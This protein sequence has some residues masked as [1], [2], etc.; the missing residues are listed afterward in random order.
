MEKNEIKFEEALERLEEI[1]EKLESGEIT[2]DDSLHLYENGV[3]LT[4]ECMNKIHLI[5]GKV[6]TLKEEMDG[7]FEETD[8]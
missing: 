4:K 5:E 3:K 7:T 2:L 1:I 8:F 6:K